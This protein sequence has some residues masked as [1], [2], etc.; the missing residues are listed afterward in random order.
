VDRLNT[1]IKVV[2]A[3][4]IIWRIRM[5]NNPEQTMQIIQGLS[6]EPAK[7]NKTLIHNFEL[8]PCYP[9]PFNASTRVNYFLAKDGFVKLEII[10]VHGNQVDSLVAEYKKAGNHQTS[11]NSHRLS[12]GLYF[13][14][15]KFENA[16]KFQKILLIK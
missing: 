16:V 6:V 14:K 13:V 1:N 8:N 10:N 9:N 7:T 15:M 12:S 4:E 3:E 11:F 5:K 2:S